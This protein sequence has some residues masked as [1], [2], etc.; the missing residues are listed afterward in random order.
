MDEKRR[1]F[2]K[3]I[4]KFIFSDD[5]KRNVSAL[6]TLDAD[7]RDDDSVDERQCQPWERHALLKRLRTFRCV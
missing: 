3:L 4:S 2:D 6:T 5:L 1:V 7:P